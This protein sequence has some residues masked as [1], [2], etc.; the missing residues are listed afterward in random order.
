MLGKIKDNPWR[1]G[2]RSAQV[3]CA[4]RLHR[5]SQPPVRGGRG[6]VLGQVPVGARITIVP[7]VPWGT[8]AAAAGPQTG[9]LGSATGRGKKT[10]PGEQV[11][12]CQACNLALLNY[13]AW[14]DFVQLSPSWLP[15]PPTPA[16]QHFL[17][18]F[19]SKMWGE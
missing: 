17:G 7:L 19:S 16:A 15:S 18:L 5:S 2:G 6:L 9:L 13:P 3:G 4:R 10:S 8:L 1:A 14:L 12:K 11:S